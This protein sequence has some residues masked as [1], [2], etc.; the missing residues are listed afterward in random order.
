MSS[1]EADLRAGPRIYLA[2]PHFFCPNRGDIFKT[3]E[4]HCE[5]L[6]LVGIVTF[7]TPVRANAGGDAL[8]Q[9]IRD[10]NMALIREADGVIANLQ[11]FHGPGAGFGHAVRG[12]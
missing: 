11:N 1:V 8:A 2:G 4:Q 7:D 3:L 5:R 12:E 9:S 10:A 6:G